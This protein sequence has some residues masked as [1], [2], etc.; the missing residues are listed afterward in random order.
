MKEKPKILIVDDRV[1]N[2]KILNYFLE[3]FDVEIVTAQSGNEALKKTLNTEFA[4]MIIDVNMP[5]MDGY[6]TVSILRQSK[7]TKYMPIMFISSMHTDVDHIE[8]GIELGAV[9]FI[10]RPIK[11]TIMQGKVR[12]FLDLYIQRKELDRTVQQ[13]QQTNENLT[14]EINYR[15]QVEKKLNLAKEKAEE[16]DMLKSA[17]LANMSHEIRTPMNAICGFSELLTEFDLGKEEQKEYIHII[18]DN[19]NVLLRLI[20]DIIDISKI[21]SGQLDVFKEEVNINHVLEDMYNRYKRELENKNKSHVEL[22]LDIVSDEEIVLNTDRTRFIQI[23]NNVLGNAV[24]YTNKGS[25]RFGYNV[26]DNKDLLFFVKDT[27]EGIPE[28]KKEIIFQR[29]M[30]VDNSRTINKGGTGLGLAICKSLVEVL[31]GEIWFES[32][33]GHG[34]VFYFSH[35]LDENI[36]AAPAKKIKEN[37]TP[38]WEDKNILVIEDVD[39]NFQFLNAAL[40]KT[41]ANLIHIDNGEDAVEFVENH[42]EIDL[43]LLDIQLPGINGYEVAQSIRKFNNN[44]KIIAQT[45]YAMTGERENCINAGCDDYISKPIKTDELL[46][47]ISL[48]LTE[49]AYK[50][51]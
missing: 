7:A 28:D 20:D 44:I 2:I 40:S 17:F 37:F 15:K 12:A 48:H 14:K 47:L 26:R 32:K 21:D 18:N 36:A 30:K 3:K 16:S 24:K 49:H 25:I 41:N 5:E 46:N 27:G 35:P 9:D 39:F 43:I 11:P 8:K 6:E 34:A 38:N 22:Y 4:L 23:L 29:F 50:H 10:I 45:A 1:E 42:R 51:A 31:G 33:A 13:L 19:T